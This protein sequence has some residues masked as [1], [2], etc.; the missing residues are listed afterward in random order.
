MFSSQSSEWRTPKE[1]YDRL[2]KVFKFDLD[3]C[4]TEDNPLGTRYYYTMETDGLN[5]QWPKDV[6]SVFINPP[7]NKEIETWLQKA[8]LEFN[9]ARQNIKY[10]VFL[11]PARTDTRWFHDYIYTP[12][13]IQGNPL[14][15][16]QI[17]FLKG[18]LKFTNSKN[19]APFPSMICI[20]HK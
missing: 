9:R 4:T 10:I 6:E 15:K 14:P 5:S 17:R 12:V 8:M 11:L 19:S 13:S 16:I 18:R 3:P 7:Y 2:N 20:F 1:L